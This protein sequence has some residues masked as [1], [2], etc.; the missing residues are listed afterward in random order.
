MIPRCWR[1]PPLP[2][3]GARS[4]G[5]GLQV[6]LEWI[7]GLEQKRRRPTRANRCSP[8][9]QPMHGAGKA[10]LLRDRGYA[11]SAQ[12]SWAPS[13]WN[14]REWPAADHRYETMSSLSVLFPPPS[15]L[16][17][18]HAPSKASPTRAFVCGRKTA[19]STEPSPACRG[20]ATGARP[21]LGASPLSAFA[22]GA[23][24]V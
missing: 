5:G 15:T 1:S 13:A 17:P 21:R 10:L 16:R 24:N 23:A 14:D 3:P 11:E 18:A 22:G 19:C 8:E 6:A 20:S 4:A 2:W 9:S 12:G 7:D